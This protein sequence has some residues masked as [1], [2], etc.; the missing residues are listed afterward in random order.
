[1]FHMECIQ[2]WA[3]RTQSCP[4]CRTSIMD[5]NEAYKEGEEPKEGE[6]SETRN[7]EH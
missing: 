2:G 3:E 4:L 6:D 5:L 7:R 1:M